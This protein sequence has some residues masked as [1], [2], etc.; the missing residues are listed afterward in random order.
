MAEAGT[1]DIYGSEAG[2]RHPEL[3]GR[4]REIELVYWPSPT[5]VRIN[6]PS[7][8]LQSVGHFQVEAIR[9]R[10]KSGSVQNH[11]DMIDNRR[12]TWA[13]GR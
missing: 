4:Q 11:V 5:D 3:Q 13:G 8:S 1:G 9:S 10:R 7:S 6:T 2:C 12:K